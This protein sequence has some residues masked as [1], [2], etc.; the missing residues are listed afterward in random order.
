MNTEK[1]GSIDVLNETIIRVYPRLS[2]S[3]FSFGF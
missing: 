2:V 3:H 1:Q